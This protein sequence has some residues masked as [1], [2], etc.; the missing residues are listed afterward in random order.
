MKI[1]WRGNL[2]FLLLIL[3]LR[4][5]F[6]MPLGC[7]GGVDTNDSGPAH[8]GS[9]GP[10]AGS[11]GTSSTTN[12][13]FK[14]VSITPADGS[15]AVALNS[16]IQISFSQEVSGS[17]VN[18][19]TV[20]LN[21]AGAAVSATTSVSGTSITITPAQLLS[22][23]TSYQL[24]VTTDVTASD[25]TKLSA[26]ATSSFQTGSSSPQTLA[27]G[28]IN[29]GKMVCTETACIFFQNVNSTTDGSICSVPTNGG[30]V[31][32][33]NT[34]LY[35]PT[36]LSVDSTNVYFIEDYTKPGN[37]EIY[38]CPLSQISSTCNRQTV[39][40]AAGVSYVN[41]I[42]VGS[43]GIFYGDGTSAIK[44]V[45]LATGKSST[46]CS[47]LTTPV[48]TRLDSNNVI[49][50]HGSDFKTIGVCAQDG[51][52]S[53]VNVVTAT[54]EV[55]DFQSD[56]TSVY[57]TDGT[58]GQTNG[59]M[60]RVS[61]SGGSVTSLTSSSQEF[62][63]NPIVISGDSLYVVSGGTIYRIKKDGS[64]SQA[65]QSG[66]IGPFIAVQGNF[67]YFFTN[68]ASTSS[69]ARIAIQ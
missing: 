21:A 63:N 50:L 61:V 1:W 55:G 18:S 35:Q 54:N 57:F 62:A 13:V 3:G 44:V 11:G 66:A 52:G 53:P 47:G 8:V 48:V 34:G 2:F 49:Y 37:K 33:F 24:S 9:G 64:S 7:G 59:L 45:S 17:S 41:G 20:G 16:S 65:M 31:N 58:N 39:A 26:A 46:V 56:G 4:V 27:T 68:S 5:P 6:L 19:T 60:K 67:V 36:Q 51:S 12:S 14:V 30:S 43:R 22:P 69:L 42:P 29:L 15:T 25:G 38:S 10:S 40:S 32:C 28:I 23:L